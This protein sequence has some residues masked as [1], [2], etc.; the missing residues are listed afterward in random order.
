[1]NCKYDFDA[2]IKI[3]E[4]AHRPENGSMNGMYFKYNLIK[5][6]MHNCTMQYWTNGNSKILKDFFI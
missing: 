4:Q 5:I 2:N 3:T 6:K 1:M